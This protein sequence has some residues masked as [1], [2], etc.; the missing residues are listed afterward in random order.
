[1]KFTRTLKLMIIMFT[2]VFVNAN[3]I[4]AQNSEGNILSPYSFYGLGVLDGQGIASIQAMGGTCIAV[5]NPYI[6]NTGNPA[7]YT[8]APQQTM[9]YS[10]G[11]SGTNSY[12]KSS[13]GQTSNNNFTLGDLSAQFPIAKNLGAAVS[14]SPYSSVGYRIS[15]VDDSEDYLT[16]IGE[17]KYSYLGSG[18]VGLV[19]V[20]VGWEPVKNLSVG[21]NLINYFGNI[22]RASTVDIYPVTSTNVTYRSTYAITDWYINKYGG[23]FGL[24]YDVDFKHDRYLTFGVVYA[25]KL[26]T[27]IEV[28]ES[29]YTMDSSNADSVYYNESTTGL[30]IPSKLSAGIAYRTA[31]M[32]L[33]A[34]Y[35]YQDWDSAMELNEIDNV[36]FT[37]MHEVSA[38]FEYTPNRFDLRHTLK[39]WTYRAGAKA[40][41]SYMMFNNL[42]IREYSGS[43]GVSVPMQRN[44]GSMLNLAAEAGKRGSVGTEG[45]LDEV[46]FKVSIGFTFFTTQ[47]WFIRQKFK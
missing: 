21:V 18:G 12:L 36:Q 2:M 19:K 3:Y 42:K 37:S 27:D 44:G 29:R 34:D 15:V 11:M 45:I 43:L 40:G 17:V 20:G 46:F 23:E 4:I 24:Q 1:M 28:T 30:I 10:F 33:A 14:Y 6:V 47:E 22:S 13:T 16:D 35:V 25:P 31:K 26:K 32:T 9:L 5:K 38:G 39:R 41:N 7:S 8:V